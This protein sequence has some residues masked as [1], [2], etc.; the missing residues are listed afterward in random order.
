MVETSGSGSLD[1]RQA[2]S[3]EAAARSSGLGVVVVMTSQR[4]HL[5]DNTT[6]FLL[7]SL[8]RL[9]WEDFTV[10]LNTLRDPSTGA[11]KTSRI[12]SL[13]SSIHFLTRTFWQLIIFWRTWLA[14][15]CLWQN[16]NII[17]GSQFKF[18]IFSCEMLH[19]QMKA[20]QLKIYI[21]ITALSLTFILLSVITNFP[22]FKLNVNV[23]KNSDPELKTILLWNTFSGDKTFGLRYK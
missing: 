17:M 18:K 20:Q 22:Y 5:T 23:I 10:L 11:I 6:C 21:F 12:L 16:I 19:L 13:R 9:T 3:V 8:S 15:D 2:C 14:G 1:P 4:L 7:N